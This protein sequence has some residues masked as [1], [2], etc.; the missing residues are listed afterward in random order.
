MKNTKKLFNIIALTLM[1]SLSNMSYAKTS[2]AQNTEIK[3]HKKKKN[4]KETN[5][6][7][8]INSNLLFYGN[9]DSLDDL[10]LSGEQ[11]LEYQEKVEAIFYKY[12]SLYQTNHKPV[13]IE[14]LVEVSALLQPM[15]SGEQADFTY[16]LEDYKKCVYQQVQMHQAQYSQYINLKNKKERDKF[17]EFSE[18]LL[19]VDE[20]RIGNFS[21]RKKA[22]FIL[23]L[24]N[25][26]RNDGMCTK[27]EFI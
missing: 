23:R 12:Y 2:E 15:K 22:T 6:I 14:M 24:D 9:T 13:V 27:D 25:R 17:N 8:M 19:Q 26:P 10:I 18:E 20:M 7:L 1:L 3:N 11:P 16:C 4:N 21:S 5:D